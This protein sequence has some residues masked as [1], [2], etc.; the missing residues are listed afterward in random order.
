MRSSL[1]VS[2]RTRCLSGLL[3]AV[4]VT[5]SGGLTLAH[6]GDAAAILTDVRVEDPRETPGAPA[7]D[8]AQC[9]TCRTLATAAHLTAPPRPDPVHRDAGWDVELAARGLGHVTRTFT[10]PLAARPPP[11]V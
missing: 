11:L 10:A 1:A 8:E 3:L 2:F 5:V 6:A 7:H 4:Q 9:L